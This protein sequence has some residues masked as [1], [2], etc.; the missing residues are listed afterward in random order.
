MEQSD[1]VEGVM[2][3]KILLV[4]FSAFI[5]NLSS[6]S[7]A[8]KGEIKVFK[9]KEEKKEV[10]KRAPVE[11]K[12]IVPQKEVQALE[13]LESAIDVIITLIEETEDDDPQKPEYLARLAE[14]Y[15]DKSYTYFMKAYSNE[16][17]DA[18]AN[19]RE[20]GNKGEEDALIDKQNKLLELQ[21]HWQDESIKTYKVIIEKN[22]DYLNTDMVLYYL[23]Y[24]LSSIGR[25]DEGIEYFI[26]LIRD[27]PQSH[28]VPDAFLN[29]G[30]YYF[31]NGDMKSA[32]KIYEKVESFPKSTSYTMAVYK[33]GWAYYNLGKYSEAMDRF[34]R[35]IKHSEELL[36]QGINPKIQLINEAMRDLV[37][38]YISVGSEDK[39]VSFF[40]EIVPEKYIELSERLALAYSENG[41]F[42]K[43]NKLYKFII[44][45]NPTS[46]KIIEYMR[47]ISKNAYKIGI[48]KKLFEEIERWIAVY[49][50]FKNSAPKEYI[51]VEEANLEED[52][53]SYSSLYHEEVEKTREEEGM[54]IVRNLYSEY[55]RFFPN[56]PE[57]YSITWNYATLLSQ[58]KE[59]KLAAE[60]YE[61]V[62]EIDPEGKWTKEAAHGAMTSYYK[63]IDVTE[64]GGVKGEE[65]TDLAPKE[66]PDLYQKMVNACNR[67]LKFASKDDPERPKA[68][69]TSSNIYYIFNHFEPAIKGFEEFINTYPDHEYTQSAARLLLSSFHLRRDIKNLNL[70]ADKIGGMPNINKGDLAKIVLQIKDQAEF[71]RCFV[72]E[73]EKK[74]KKAGDCFIGYVEKFPDTKL[75]D[76][77]LFFAGNNYFNAR[78]VEKALLANEKLYN[79]GTQTGFNSPLIPNALFNIGEVYRKLAVYSESAR[80]YEIFVERHPNHKLVEDALRYAITFRMGLGEYDNAIKDLSLYLKLFPKSEHTPRL[81]LDIGLIYEKKAKYRDAY[82]HFKSYL[83]KYG[84]RGSPDLLLLCHLKIGIS[85][86]KLGKKED[87]NN[88]FYRV[89][90][91]Y[92]R[93]GED[94]IKKLTSTG[95]SA[96]AEARFMMGEKILEEMRDIQLKLPEK[97]LEELIIKKLNLVKSS[98]DIFEDV[99]KFEQPHW[100]I[101]AYS[102]KGEGYG[103][104]ATAIEN[105]PVP[106]KLKGEAVLI[107]KQALMEKA[108]TVWDRSKEEYNKCV[109]L[110]K[111]LKWF[112]EFSEKCERELMKLDPS[113]R[114]LPDLRATPSFYTPNSSPPSFLVIKEGEERPQWDDPQI[115]ENLK[116]QIKNNPQN[117]NAIYNYALFK[118]IKGN[119]EDAEK[120]YKELLSNYPQF[121]NP[122]ARLA[123]L[124]YKRGNKEMAIKEFETSITYDKTQ[125]SSNNYL[126]YFKI[127]EKNF[128]EAQQYARAVLVGDPDNINAYLNLAIA[129]YE[130]GLYEVGLLVCRN[131]LEIKP[132]NPYILNIAGLLT[133][134]LGDVKQAVRFFEQ[135]IESKSSMIDPHLNLGAITLNYKDFETAKTHFELVLEVDKNNPVAMMSLAVTLRGLGMGDSALKIYNDLLKIYPSNIDIHYNLCLLY[136]ENLNDYQKALDECTKFS[137]LIP[138]EHSKKK[139]VIT[140]I[141]GI[142]IMMEELKEEKKNEEIKK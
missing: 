88:E 83:K 112:N 52:L 9:V 110:A 54:E 103:E 95:F 130:M 118:E 7:F 60:A 142:K 139:E 56:S 117:K 5:L 19:A 136:Q 40:K 108:Q 36:K 115:E 85:L 62:I 122:R 137:S 75:L 44:K 28:Y 116:N 77:A 32:L 119:I 134:K 57:I 53:R 126:S 124:L 58:L 1:N 50:K 25:N 78:L 99:K 47:K 42:E 37:M 111:Q 123:V 69:F 27:F 91:I 6:R 15:W 2:R 48:K 89:I 26:K 67:Y 64:K 51:E 101:A 45:E 106:P 68:I 10:D 104:L 12:D 105:A 120:T 98:M 138:P 17:M 102:R 121:A 24:N 86:W 131:A 39:A 72:F 113:F 16:I 3:K 129:Y 140:R 20:K 65:T 71:N 29:I 79:M 14:L 73:N 55:L 87:A 114:S 84:E 34:L 76:K 128:A 127:E 43:S 21:E 133:L 125:S 63:F 23:G 93:L 8:Q 135:A 74:Y 92:N 11:F 59:Y 90:E 80:F 70:W 61:K 82:N 18:I 35:V 13:K 41:L 141:E 31:N 46:Y 100:T 97:V 4:I 94:E 81:Y 109:E 38:V 33:E 66:I 132:K 96:A 22:P 107:Y 30:E 49:E